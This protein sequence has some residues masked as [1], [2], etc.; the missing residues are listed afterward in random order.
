MQ[1]TIFLIVVEIVLSF[2]GVL[3]LMS[4]TNEKNRFICVT[5]QTVGIVLLALF[6][7]IIYRWR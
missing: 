7:V 3:F 6:I 4:G 2:L 1:K 5:D